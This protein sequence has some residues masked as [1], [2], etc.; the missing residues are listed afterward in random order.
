M[1]RSGS[2]SQENYLKAIFKLQHERGIAS[3]QAIAE[4]LAATPAAVTGMLHKL[5]ELDWIEY[6][7]YQGAKLTAKGR[8]IATS[9]IRKHRLWEVFL[10]EK[11]QFKWDAVHQ[12]AEELEH[13]GDANFTNRLDAFLGCP[14]TDPHGDP[15]PDSNGDWKGNERV[16]SADALKRKQKFTVRGVSNSA[17]DFLRHL[18]A[19]K[20]QLGKHFEVMDFFPFD[21]SWEWK[22]D[23]GIPIRVSREVAAQLLV[24]AIPTNR[25]NE[26][27]ES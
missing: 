14:S 11:L 2:I 1:K 9:T 4:K 3:N 8:Q 20:I 24:E 10:V 22:D 18:D 15:I 12:W 25:G 17:S 6:T 7:A 13:I 16:F 21:G 5:T 27:Q 23:H 26:N 19:L